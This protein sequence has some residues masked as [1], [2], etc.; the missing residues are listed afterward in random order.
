[1][2]DADNWDCLAVYLDD[3]RDELL[4]EVVVQQRGPVVVDEVDEK[5]FDV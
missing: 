4:Q 3:G 2:A 5:P 1:M